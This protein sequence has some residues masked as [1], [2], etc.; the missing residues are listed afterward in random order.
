MNP[1]GFAG[2]FKITLSCH[3]WEIAEERAGPPAATP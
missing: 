2:Q 1:A 3:A